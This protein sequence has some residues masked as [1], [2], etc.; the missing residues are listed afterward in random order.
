MRYNPAMAMKIQ[1]SAKIKS[2]LS[3]M[4]KMM[5]GDHFHVHGHEDGFT[6]HHM[7]EGGAPH[8]PMEHKT[9]GAAKQQ[10]AECMNGECEE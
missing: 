8:G 5:P 4:G 2:M 3:E 7:P 6:T 10:M 9:I 1:H